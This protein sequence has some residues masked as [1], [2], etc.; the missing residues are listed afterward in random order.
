MMPIFVVHKFQRP[1]SNMSRHGWTNIASRSLTGNRKSADFDS[2][3]IIKYLLTAIEGV[4]MKV[5]C[6]MDLFCT[7]LG[8]FNSPPPKQQRQPPAGIYGS[9]TAR[10]FWVL[11]C[12]FQSEI[13][14]LGSPSACRAGGREFSATGDRAASPGM[15]CGIEGRCAWAPRKLGVFL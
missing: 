11:G 6:L 5:L 12:I 9:G 2:A 13:P 15:A 1:S 7:F 3:N 14:K 4:P 8:W 10:I